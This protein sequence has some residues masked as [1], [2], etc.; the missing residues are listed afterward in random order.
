MDPGSTLE[1]QEVRCRNPRCHADGRREVL[2]HAHLPAD[3]DV[4]V[5]LE[6]RCPRCGWYTTTVS[7]G[8]RVVKAGPRLVRLEESHRSVG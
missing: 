4:P 3:G 2:C 8:R 1:L 6:H 7:P 5:V